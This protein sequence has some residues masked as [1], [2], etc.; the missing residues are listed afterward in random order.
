MRKILVKFVLLYLRILAK[1][2][3]R[4]IKPLIIGVGGA[5]GKSSLARL[6]YL[7]LSNSLKV[8]YS[9][10]KN[11][12]TGIPLNILG[13]S[14]ENYSALNWLKAFMLAPFKTIFNWTRFDVYVAEMGIDSPKEPKNM[15]YLLKIIKPDIAVLTNVSFEHSLY[16]EEEVSG[17]NLEAKEKEIFKLTSE[18]ELLLLN[19]LGKTKTAVL[20]LDD[21]VISGAEGKLR[22]KKITV[23]RGK[24]AD[25]RITK[26]TSSL[27]GFEMEFEHL[28]KRHIL[29][30]KRP[31]TEHFS[32]SITLAIAVCSL[33]GV[34]VEDT[35]S[36]IESKFSLPAGRMTVFP[37]IKNSTI[38]DSSYN[39]S[40]LPLFDMLDFLKSCQAKRKVVILGDMR[41]LGIL[42][43]KFHA[44]AAGKILNAA[45][46]AI[47][48][49]PLMKEYAYPILKK[50]NLK[51][52]SFDNFTEAKDYVQNFIEEGDLILVKGSQN[53]LYLE[54]VVEMLLKNPKDKEKLCRRG[55]SWDKKRGQ[56][57]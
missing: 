22:C 34:K 54:R 38:I 3:L 10:G 14:M 47:L 5:S 2:Q 29:K 28:N 48:I 21:K 9:E 41:E 1:I 13:I 20:N 27:S 4:K 11:S 56:S 16:F 50:S 40:P 17:E 37:G 19:S 46:A 6:I 23:S 45:N 8:L 18:Q 30:L 25:F 42:S 43:K 53:T 31:L 26:V 15:S 44:E 33:L 35:I 39:S 52:E 55:E 32:Y 7:I 24:P 51:V 49:G 57:L 12:E 36:S